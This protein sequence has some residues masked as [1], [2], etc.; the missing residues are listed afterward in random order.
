M[1]VTEKS[2][3]FPKKVDKSKAP[4]LVQPS[5]GGNP[6]RWLE[7]YIF[8]E[9]PTNPVLLELRDAGHDLW[10]TYSR[11]TEYSN[12]HEKYEYESKEFWE[13]SWEDMGVG[14]IKAALDHITEETQQKVGLIGYSMGTTQIFSAMSLDYEGYYKDRVYKVAQLAPCTVTD[15]TMYEGFNMFTVGTIKA[16]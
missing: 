12:V 6:H 9:V 5:L 8:N 1:H 13:F 16:L 7:N 4:I 11:G 10:F 2:G 14:D 3:L 15:P